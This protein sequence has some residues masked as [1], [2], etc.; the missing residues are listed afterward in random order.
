MGIHEFL[1][2]RIM[3]LENVSITAG[4]FFTGPLAV[5]GGLA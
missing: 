4:G 2:K 3:Q 5:A 1:A